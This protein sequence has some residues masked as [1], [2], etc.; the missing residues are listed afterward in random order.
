LI[1][2]AEL[3]WFFA[4]DVHRMLVGWF[5]DRFGDG[6][7]EERTDRYLVLPA[8]GAVG[9]KLRE[10]VGLEIKVRTDPPAVVGV[11]G[12]VQGVLERWAK[13]SSRDPALAS[14][15]MG[16]AE[17]DGRWVDVWKR[18]RL[19]PLAAPGA[20][21]QPFQADH[22]LGGHVEMTEVEAGPHR[23][24]T[25]A[26]EVWGTPTPSRESVEAVCASAFDPASAFPLPLAE[27]DSVS[28]PGWLEN[29]PKRNRGSAR[30]Y[31]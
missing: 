7:V 15:I 23:A 5:L 24:V 20:G 8:G 9:I 12:G 4:G 21:A 30:D 22:P 6:G 3:R 10:G 31:R 28:Y 13:W 17:S 25:V 14:A 1:R 26:L 2:T 19:W 11:V 29:L 18:R 16:A 27:A